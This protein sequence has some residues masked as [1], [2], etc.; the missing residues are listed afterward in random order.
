MAVVFKYMLLVTVKIQDT[1]SATSAVVLSERPLPAATTQLHG[2]GKQYNAKV[3]CTLCQCYVK[4][5]KKK[6]QI[7]VVKCVYIRKG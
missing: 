2:S 4:W 6:Y 1:Y 3:P 5:S 7:M